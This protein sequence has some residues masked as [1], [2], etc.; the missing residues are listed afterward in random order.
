MSLLAFA[1]ESLLARYLERVLQVVLLHLRSRHR[2]PRGHHVSHA[3]S[4][5]KHAGH[6]GEQR[7][8]TATEGSSVASAQLGRRSGT[9]AKAQRPRGRWRAEAW[10]SAALALAL[11]ITC[12]LA[13]TFLSSLRSRTSALSSAF[14]G[15]R[16]PPPIVRDDTAGRRAGN[17]LLADVAGAGRRRQG[18]DRHAATTPHGMLARACC[19]SFRFCF[20][21]HRRRA[22]PPGRRS[23]S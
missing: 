6:P 3:G 13:M 2:R 4:W 18:A 5:A 9:A 15:A 7:M 16:V 23:P 8:R 11:G 17:T 21:L 19:L 22:A 1:V 14:L 10:A 12:I 20:V